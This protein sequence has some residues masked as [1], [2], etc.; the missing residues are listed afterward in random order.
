M[1]AARLFV[2][3]DLA[4]DG[5]IPLDEAQVHYL[6]H[7]MRRPDGAPLL[8]F[9]GRDGEWLARVAEAGKRG[10]LLLCEVQTVLY[11]NH[12]ASS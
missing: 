12:S 10:G 1:S 6:R 9:N 11:P 4:A 8:L 2:A 3:A 5:E 7:V